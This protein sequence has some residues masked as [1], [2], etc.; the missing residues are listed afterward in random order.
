MQGQG[1]LLEVIPHFT[2]AAAHLL[3][4]RQQ[5]TDEDADY[6][7]DDE[8]PMSVKPRRRVES[9]EPLRESR[10]RHR[11]DAG[12]SRAEHHFDVSLKSSSASARR[13]P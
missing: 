6:G 13:R 10:L 7:D 12:E 3:N 2:W 5:Q 9:M 4:G 11:T 1:D 8:K